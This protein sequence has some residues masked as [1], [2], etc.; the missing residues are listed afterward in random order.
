MQKES[1]SKLV[2]YYNVSDIV[3]GIMLLGLVAFFIHNYL[4]TSLGYERSCSNY[5]MNPV[6]NSGNY[7]SGGVHSIQPR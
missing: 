1:G 7:M 5:V 4:S 2:I 6:G 3:L